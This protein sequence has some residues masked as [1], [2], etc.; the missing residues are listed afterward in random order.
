[1][2]DFKFDYCHLRG[3]EV[4]NSSAKGLHLNA[5]VSSPWA[6]GGLV[7]EDSLVR[8]IVYFL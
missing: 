5:F 4:K 2:G 6:L 8:T 1:M 3:G 7:K